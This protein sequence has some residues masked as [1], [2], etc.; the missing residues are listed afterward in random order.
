MLLNL[1]ASES[2]E[3]DPEPFNASYYRRS[4]DN[5]GY[6]FRAPYRTGEWCSY[7][8]VIYL[9]QKLLVWKRPPPPSL[10]L[11]PSFSQAEHDRNRHHGG[12]GQHGGGDRDRRKN[13]QTCRWAQPWR[14]RLNPL[15]LTEKVSEESVDACFSHRFVW[16]VHTPQFICPLMPLRRRQPVAL[17]FQILC[18]SVTLF[19]CELDISRTP[20]QNV[21]KFGPNLQM[22]SRMDWWI[23]V[24]KETLHNMKGFLYMW[25]KRSLGPNNDLIRIWRSNV[26][27]TVTLPNPFLPSGVI[28]TIPGENSFKYFCILNLFHWISSPNFSFYQWSE[29]N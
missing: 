14:K 8:Q 10:S 22:D 29:W 4:L 13:H 12:P 27:V 17:Y 19:P 25:H 11:L 6:I 24:I 16:H 21:F 20:C 18:P 15:I 28:L 5:K 26:Q 23:L 1:R 2:W 7:S 9:T 3:E